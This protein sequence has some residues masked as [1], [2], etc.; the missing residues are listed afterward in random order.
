MALI[1]TPV[2]N[3]IQGVSQQPD[4]LR[5]AGQC[6][7][8]ENALSSVADGLKKR[9]NTRHI[10]KILDE[11][12]SSNSFIHF[13]DRD[14]REKYVFIHD[15][16]KIRAFNLNTGVAGL[17]NNSINGYT[18][19]EDDY[20]HSTNPR[21]DLKAM[22]VGDSTFI[23]NTTKTV[24]KSPVITDGYDRDLAG[25]FVKQG[26]YG[27]EYIIDVAGTKV[28]TLTA[29]NETTDPVSF[30][31]TI[32]GN[33][34]SNV[35]SDWFF[36][37]TDTA[38]NNPTMP[39]QNPSTIYYDEIDD[40]LGITTNQP[41]FLRL[42][43]MNNLSSD[44]VDEVVNSDG[45]TT[46]PFNPER[47]TSFDLD[48]NRD[49]FWST[50][51][52]VKI[53]LRYSWSKAYVGSD[54]ITR[55]D[56]FFDVT[57]GYDIN[58]DDDRKRIE[59]ITAKPLTDP[60]AYLQYLD[61]YEYQKR[62]NSYNLDPTDGNTLLPPSLREYVIFDA[63]DI[64][65]P[66]S[67]VRRFY[68]TGSATA[69]SLS[70]ASIA[71]ALVEGTSSN[72]ENSFGQSR[73][74]G[75]FTFISYRTD[76]GLI[77]RNTSS[78]S[79]TFFLQNT[80]GDPFVA[81]AQDG[82]SG[83]GLGMFYE[84]IDSLSSLPLE[85]KRDFAIKIIGDA[86]LNQDDFYVK[87]KTTGSQPFGQGSW[88]ETAGFRQSKGLDASTMPH[89]I[90]NSE[91]NKFNVE[92]VNYED[93][94]AGDDDTNPHPSFVDN[95]IK[96]IFLYKNRLGFVSNENVIM[97]GSGDLFNFYR[98]TVTTLLDDDRIDVSVASGRVLNLSSAVGFQ[99]NLILFGDN[100]QFALSGGDILTPKTVSVNPITNFSLEDQVTPLPL[101]SYIYFPFT[102]GAFTG[103]REFTVN[104][105]TDNYDSTEV[106]EHVPAYV[107]KNIIDMAGTTSE[108]IIVLLSGDEKG[109][110]YLYNY[111]WSSNQK[112]L[113]AWSK[114]TF[115]GE[116]QGIEFID[117]SLYF[118]ITNNE[119]TNLV[120]MPLESGLTDDAGF[121]THLDMRVSKTVNS[122]TS[123]IVLPYKPTDDL[124]VYTKD[125][126]KLN[127]DTTN[128]TQVE[129]RQY[130]VGRLSQD[131][132]EDPSLKF[133]S[134]TVGSGTTEQTIRY[135]AGLNNQDVTQTVYDAIEITF[136]ELLELGFSPTS[137]SIKGSPIEPIY[138]YS[139]SLLENV[140]ED[141][142]VWAGIPYTMKYTFSEQLFKAKAG[143]S[144]SPSN[145]AKLLIRNG[146]IYFD[147]TAHFKVKVTPKFRDTYE[148]VFTPNVI[149]SSRIGTLK[150]DTGFFRFPVLTKAQDTTI[151][152]END[153]ALP[154]NFQSAEF[155]SFLHSRSSR[156]A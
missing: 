15:G 65:S 118:V 126:L 51:N 20:L 115:T 119:E 54:S 22:T 151:T 148:N 155:E 149:G 103:M 104:A 86:E 82:L 30:N 34:S 46:A 152:I 85:C 68:K 40:E 12:L 87:F 36:N 39:P 31:F 16:T 105:T 69:S 109:S 120:E 124:Q 71:N 47:V 84:E 32:G 14:D 107:P 55:K 6:E 121:I 21:V 80:V 122:N 33:T 92:A 123:E 137:S 13:I 70:S 111:F 127:V 102:R 88:V 48:R 25:F 93:R 142:D 18:P 5:F 134:V 28:P 60:Y 130:V 19:S 63:D 57:E 101:G 132:V 38:I 79:S 26:D 133:Y 43:S 95:K 106:T 42:H 144:T 75:D 98:K 49:G 97:S 67:N 150:L 143:N 91:V 90:I 139:I 99:E 117:S 110:L 136:S 8:Q 9:P 41:T 154:S 108:D 37:T 11:E 141:T 62:L 23:V 153:S 72:A 10:G 44:Y 53:F 156:Y 74:N 64:K 56:I 129:E 114:F 17:I 89:R 4:S 116:I 81:S 77:T 35:I 83:E 147:K 96:N 138:E 76:G 2:P 112:V 146:S 140:T 128:P 50:D 66:A 1:N 113:S 94:E 27:R 145:A 7:E 3:L 45:T 135:Y 59:S 131:G 29:V 78:R 58:Y 24:S 73:T 100:G 61:S 52:R 125:G